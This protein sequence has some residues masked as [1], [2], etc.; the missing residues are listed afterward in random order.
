MQPSSDGTPPGART[1]ARG[2]AAGYAAGG[3]QRRIVLLL[4]SLAA[5]SGGA[6]LAGTQPVLAPNA[7]RPPNAKT[8]MDT[9]AANLASAV[10]TH[11]FG[12]LPAYIDGAGF[13][14]LPFD[15]FRASQPG[16]TTRQV[17]R[18]TVPRTSLVLDTAMASSLTSAQARE[19]AGRYRI[20]VSLDG[21]A[22]QSPSR[23]WV[24]YR[25]NG[26]LICRIYFPGDL[27]TLNMGVNSLVLRP[28]A[29]G[30]HVL[31]V[32][33]VHRLPGGAPATL[34]TDYALNVLPRKPNARE[35]AS[36]PHDDANPA[37]L[38][39]TPLT[40]RAPTR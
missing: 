4:I 7:V 39:N 37:S 24:F 16:T 30:P 32:V 2:P 5:W 1:P 9:N 3:V 19:D 11:A 27:G 38:G 31:R 15:V 34:V 33:A 28:L 35:Q 20:A 17:Y 18:L 6:A 10:I 40:F 12:Q 36:A 8:D 23:F 25:N 29:P 14:L 13:R 26:P 21:A 22:V